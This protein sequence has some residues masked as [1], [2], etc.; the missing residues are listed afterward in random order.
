MGGDPE[1]LQTIIQLFGPETLRE[2]DNSSLNV[3][4]YKGILT[5]WKMKFTQVSGSLL[6]RV[7]V[8]C[9]SP[10]LM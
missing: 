6:K 9:Q 4:D 1:A 7:C 8:V 10:S 5:E 3:D 2:Y